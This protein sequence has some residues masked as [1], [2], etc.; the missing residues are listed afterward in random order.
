MN[1]RLEWQTSL[2]SA[3]F[4]AAAYEALC[5]R[6]AQS[7]PFNSLAW[8]RAAEQALQHGCT[9]HVLLLWQGDRLIGCL[10]LVRCP[11][12]LLGMT[13]HEVRHL[14]HPLSDR[15]GLLVEVTN[16]Y[17]LER[18][19][20]AIR[21]RMPHARLQLN[22]LPAIAA[23][24]D[25]LGHWAMQ[26]WQSEARTSCRVPEH[27][28][29]EEDR[30]EATGDTRYELRRARKRT[31]ACGAIVERITPDGTTIAQCLQT[32]EAVEAASW[33]GDNGVGIFSPGPHRD[34]IIR[35]LTSLAAEG[36]VRV[37]QLS[38]EGRC[39]SYR[40]GLLDRGRLYD[41]NIAFLP[42][43]ASLGSGRLLLDEWFR[44][45]LDEGWNYIDASRVSL[46]QSNHQLHE[47]M[48]GQVEHLRWSFYSRRPSGVALGLAYRLW[49]LVKPALRAWRNRHATTRVGRSAVKQPSC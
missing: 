31:Q 7:T 27:R 35:A 2:C 26:S 30:Q 43:F 40:L 8:L 45:G 36:H 32:L 12:R 14:G 37:V 22:E 33:K 46:H 6:S 1:E 39:I 18:A 5:K 4:P 23:H 34:W 24:Q 29:S 20:K 10:P 44:W 41:Y 13:V 19:L 49:L 3:S 21:R 11:L 16:P 48:T 17:L 9:L 42:E 38:L 15:I 47:R 28:L 25:L